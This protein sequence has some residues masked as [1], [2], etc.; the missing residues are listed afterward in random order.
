MGFKKM[1]RTDKEYLFDDNSGYGSHIPALQFIFKHLNVNCAL[2]L[3]LGNYSTPFLLDH[4]SGN[5]F[6]IEMQDE[7]WMNKVKYK[8]SENKRWSCIYT[9]DKYCYKNIIDKGDIQFV[10]SDGHGD[11][12]PESVNH[13]MK[14]GIDTIVG[15]DTES[16]WYRWH[17]VQHE[18][19]WYYKYE[20]TDIA[21]YT[22]VWTKN[23]DLITALKNRT[24]PKGLICFNQPRGLGD[25]IFCQTLAHD[26]I[27]EGYKV[28]WPV[29]PVYENIQKHYPEITF[30][31]QKLLNIDYNVKNEYE[32]NGMKVYPLRYTDSL[33]GTPYKDCMKTKYWYFNKT[34]KNWKNKA[35]WVRDTMAE[36]KLFIQ[37][38]IN[39]KDK[40]CL[41]NRHF[42]T[43]GVKQINFDLPEDIKVV[44]LENIPGYTLF[45]WGKVIENAQSIHTV[46]TSINYII[47]VLNCKAEEIHLY[48]RRPDEHNFENYDFILTDKYNYI[49]HD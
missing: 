32:V 13:F 46:G 18:K 17:E 3:G 41:V 15:H 7:E 2:E 37:L 40:Y 31:N 43:G 9:E 42:L 20:F 8:Y 19:Y 28:V 38:G 45:D 10:L 12:R 24:N 27:R 44:Y 47:E 26:F 22:T 49:F 11:T 48:V 34:W 16:T 1:I 35:M 33:C 5:L 21:P 4:I 25:I 29:D 6:S 23:I 14:L 39:E 30:I 36:E